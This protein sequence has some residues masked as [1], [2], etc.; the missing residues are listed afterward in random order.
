MMNPKWNR[1]VCENRHFMCKSDTCE[2]CTYVL[3]VSYIDTPCVYQVTRDGYKICNN[4]SA[5]IEAL[6]IRLD[7]GSLK[8]GLTGTL[9]KA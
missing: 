1:C 7:R 3:W 9:R 6:A 4:I 5:M 2:N 8:I